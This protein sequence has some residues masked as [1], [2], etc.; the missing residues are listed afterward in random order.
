MRGNIMKKKLLGVLAMCLTAAMLTGCGDNANTALKDMNV[1]KYVTLGNYK[2]L[3]V[4]VA[5]PTVDEAEL[6]ATMLEVYQN[7]ITAENGITD[8]AV[9]IGDTANIDYVGKKDGVA[10]DGGTAQGYNLAIGSGQFIDGFEDG[11][12]GVKPGETVDLN[13]SFPEGYGNADLAG[14]AVVF[15][16][17]VNYIMPT[18][19]EDKA[20][21]AMGIEGVSNEEEYRQYVY[22]YLYNVAEQNYTYTVE[23]A[24]LEKFMASNVISSVPDFLLK[25]YEDASRQ[26]MEQTAASYGTDV[27]T[28]TNYFYGMNLEEFLAEYCGEAVKQDLA[29]QAVANKENLNITDE[30]LDKLLLE[31][32]NAAG[33]TTIEEYIGESSKEEYREY[34]LYQKVLGYLVENAV[35]TE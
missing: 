17:T 2:G 10:F 26:S 6:E 9:A 18:E 7:N 15:T 28:L 8:R 21:A 20:I 23:N 14:K 34:F 3:E 29:M 13:L 31:D 33:F 30:E 1:E 24:V 25:K 16:V 11:L 12:V 5:N 19:F 27:N 32:A 35:V 4:K 22:D